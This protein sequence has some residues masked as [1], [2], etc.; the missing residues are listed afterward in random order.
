VYLNAACVPRIV[1]DDRGF[2]RS[3]SLVSFAQG[4]VQEISLVWLDSDFAIASNEILYSQ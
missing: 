1:K 3:F 4:T 2:K